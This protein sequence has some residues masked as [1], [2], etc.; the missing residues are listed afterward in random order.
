MHLDRGVSQH[1]LR[2]G[3]ILA[4]TWTG[5]CV[6]RV[7]CEQGCGLDRE[8]VYSRRP[9]TR[10]VSIVLEWILVLAKDSEI[11]SWETSIFFHVDIYSRSPNLILMHL[12]W[13]YQRH[14]MQW[15]QN[16]LSDTEKWVME[17]YSMWCSALART[18]NK[19]NSVSVEMGYFTI[20]TLPVKEIHL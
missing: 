7:G 11:L 2:R 8:E 17:L 20:A 13:R 10:S 3:C 18:P 19:R 15:T 5:G 14:N 9:L 12:I 16:L 1:T 6:A 4:C